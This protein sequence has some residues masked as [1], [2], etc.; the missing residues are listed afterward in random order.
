MT[1][2]VQLPP[3]FPPPKKSGAGAAQVWL[4]LPTCDG[5]QLPEHQPSS[6]VWAMTR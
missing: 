3:V 4:L 1:L 5:W 6:Q 2:S